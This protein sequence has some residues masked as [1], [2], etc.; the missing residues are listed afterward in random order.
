MPPLMLR[1]LA[2]GLGLAG[3]VAG[4]GCAAP[5]VSRP[6]DAALVA[7][8]EATLHD[9]LERE[10]KFIKVH[11]AELLIARGEKARVRPIFEREQERNSTIPGYRIGIWRVLAATADSS[12]ERAAWIE[13]VVTAFRDPN[14]ADRVGAV[15]T[16]GKLGHRLT[17]E[18]LQ[19]ARAF[20]ETASEAEAMYAWWA[21]RLAGDARAGA[22]LI[23]GFSSPD[24]VAR[25]RAAYIANWDKIRER[26][27]LLALARAAD[28]EPRGTV[29]AAIILGAAV[30]LEADA[31]KTDEWRATL[32]DVLARGTAGE[33]YQICM[34]LAPHF[35]AQDIGRLAPLLDHENG[36]VRIGGA[37]ALLSVAERGRR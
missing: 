35:T 8:A 33:R 20:V 1:S 17:G 30:A 32:N 11:A 34:M 12:M 29:A 31:G 37:F 5:A 26:D 28:H 6:V 9:V 21:L 27:V 22:K 13:R 3:W 7:K 14:A 15:E 16:V 25:L 36:D 4:L 18:A 19:A 10:E 23:A 24:P 2:L